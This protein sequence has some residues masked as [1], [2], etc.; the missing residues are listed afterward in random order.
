M[1]QMPSIDTISFAAEPLKRLKYNLSVQSKNEKTVKVLISDKKFSFS[2]KEGVAKVANLLKQVRKVCHSKGLNKKIVA[3]RT[4]TGVELLDFYLTNN[5]FVLQHLDNGITLKVVESVLP[6]SDD[7]LASFTPLKTLGK[8]GFSLVTLVRK[9][10]SGQLFALKSLNKDHI[11][12]S[13]RISHILS[14][15]RILSKLTHPFILTLQCSF[16]TV[17][18]I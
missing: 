8:G 9:N 4:E 7:P 12:S 10:S 14:E 13:S 11:I 3:F 1:G 18:H 15:R 6:D 16:Q 2:Y 5:K 17:F